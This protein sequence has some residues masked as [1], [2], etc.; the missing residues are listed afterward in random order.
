MVPSALIRARALALGFSRVGLTPAR[1]APR[2]EAYLDWVA[3]GRQGEMHYLA[4][5][6]RLARR[7]DLQAI[8]PGARTL[9]MVAVDYGPV[10]PEPQKGVGRVAAYA[11][12]ADYHAALL[13]RLE[14]LANWLRQQS[15]Q[16]LRC[17]AYV[18]T[19]ALLERGHA[20]QAGLGFIGKNTM[21]IHPRHGSDFFLGEILTDLEVEA[22]D[23]P[24]RETQ[25]GTCARCLAACPTQAFVGP[26]VLDARRCI[27]YL[28]IEH[29]GWID[30]KLRPQMGQWVFGCDICRNVCPWQKFAPGAGSA[31]GPSWPELKP[32]LLWPASLGWFLN[33]DQA[34]LDHAFPDTALHRTGRERLVRNAC[35]AA[36]NSRDVELVPALR[37]RLED[38]SPLVRGHAAWALWQVAGRAAAPWLRARLATEAESEVR[39]ELQAGLRDA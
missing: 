33:L 14:S 23:P 13:S 6:D 9:V 24:G 2:M 35:V 37:A 18:D 19:G 26:Y 5:P 32:R 39:D 3:A 36:G 34:A 12:G 17:R 27:S 4:R 7:R 16:P 22:Y 20:Q 15:S 10:G 28:T 30:R 38:A 29:P 1:P 8:L 25:C 21:L 11:R 31:P